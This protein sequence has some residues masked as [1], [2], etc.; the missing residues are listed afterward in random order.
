MSSTWVVCIDGTG[1]EPCQVDLDPLGEADEPGADAIPEQRHPSNVVRAW[2]F[3]TE[4]RLECAVGSR[5]DDKSYGMIADLRVE[6]GPGQALYLNG[7]GTT[8]ANTV[9]RRH[10]QATGSGTSERILDAYRF[11]A[12]RW[13]PGD[14]L[15]GFGF[16]RGAFAVRSL[17]AFLG[18]VGLPRANRL[19]KAETLLALYDAYRRRERISEALADWQPSVGI[20]FLGLWDTVGA[21]AFGTTFNNF[22][23]TSP[24]T[25]TRVA[26]ALALDEVRRIFDVLPWRRTDGQTC[27]EVWFRG[28]HTNV[29][30]GYKYDQL[31]NIALVW[32]MSQANETA[33]WGIDA[34]MLPGYSAEDPVREIRN[35]FVE[36]FPRKA[37]WVAKLADRADIGKINRSILR[38]QKVHPSVITALEQHDLDYVPAA[39]VD[40][41]QP[42][43]RSQALHRAATD[44]NW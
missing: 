19:M 5:L 14:R 39:R 6:T 24:T 30:G 20:D 2:E 16:S 11:L 15:I 17:A 37:R 40:G 28:V 22:H 34:R 4:Q 12:M 8:G 44:V 43:T 3:L 26:H 13:H 29:G 31:A 36:F 23:E 42:L 25:V 32:V 7:V 9:E 21:L 1:N 10:D 18:H 35:S 27:D 41:M 38:H 33:G